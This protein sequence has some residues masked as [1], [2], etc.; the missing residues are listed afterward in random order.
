M[1][2]FKTIRDWLFRRVTWEIRANVGFLREHLSLMERRIM[3]KLDD[4][5]TALDEISTGVDAQGEKLA[6]IGLDID[7]L[8]TL[9]AGGDLQ[10]VVDKATAIKAKVQAS[11]DALTALAAKHANPTEPPPA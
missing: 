1:H 9:A 10:G 6:E 8:L 11:N 5:N 7:D 2:V 3:S 4:L